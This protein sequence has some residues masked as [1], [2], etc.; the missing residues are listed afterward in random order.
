MPEKEYIERTRPLVSTYRVD[1]KNIKEPVKQVPQIIVKRPKTSFEGTPT[2]SY[3]YSHGEECP[4]KGTINAMNNGALKLSLLNRKD[5][6]MS[7][8]P[9]GRESVA[10]C[11]VWHNPQ[12]QKIRKPSDSSVPAATQT[13]NFVPHPPSQVKMTPAATATTQYTTGHVQQTQQKTTTQATPS[14]V[15]QQQFNTMPC[16]AP[17][18]TCA[19]P[20][21][22][23]AAP[24]MSQPA[25]PTSQPAAPQ[26]P[27]TIAWAPPQME[28]V[29]G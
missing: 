27:M 15:Q 16:Q 19:A 29:C 1:F 14:N 12:E 23:Q 17:P 4:N 28:T 20:S 9:S 3:R 22:S 6:A 7:A 13:M 26:A 21:M 18:M 24:A 10:S 8:K 25:P 5:R 11:M 2:T